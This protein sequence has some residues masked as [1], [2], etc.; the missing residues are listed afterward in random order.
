MSAIFRH[1]DVGRT[2]LL[3][4]LSNRL[5]SR[6]ETHFNVALAIYN[7]PDLELSKLN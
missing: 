4:L 5:F 6:L 7:T 3:N 1:V 2:D